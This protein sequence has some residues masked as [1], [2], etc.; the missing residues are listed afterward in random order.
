MRRAGGARA[1]TARA[2][3]ARAGTARTGTA[4]TGAAT[5]AG[6]RTR[7]QAPN[8]GGGTAG[9]AERLVDPTHN[10]LGGRTRGK[11]PRESHSLK[12]GDVGVRHDSS[13]KHSYVARVT[14]FE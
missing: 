9:F 6:T 7:P 8:R 2:G 14:L 5:P 3:T 12:L 13:G 11:D 4:S 10:L 1:G